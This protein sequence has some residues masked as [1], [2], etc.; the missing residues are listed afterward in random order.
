MN[1]R[2]ERRAVAHRAVAVE[3]AADLH[4]RKHERHGGA[5]H[6]MV[7]REPRRAADT[8]HARPR[9][10]LGPALEE[11]HGPRRRV[12]RSRDRDGVEMSLLD[13]TAECRRSARSASVARA[14]ARYRAATPDCARRGR[15]TRRPRASAGSSSASSNRRSDRPGSRRSRPHLLHVGDGTLEVRGSPREHGGVDR[16]GRRAADDAERIGL[17]A[18]ATGRRSPSALRSDTRRGRL[19]PAARVL[20][21]CAQALAG[22]GGSAR[23]GEDLHRVRAAGDAMLA[24]RERRRDRPALTAPVRC[25]DSK[26]CPC[27][28]AGSSTADLFE[29]RRHRRRDTC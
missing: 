4:G 5:R 8:A 7:D 24:H 12:R 11:R 18:P 9:R 17:H 25:S 29:P 1:R 19:R 14:A 15:R 23:H 10:E 3:L 27:V 21:G 2:R 28:A 22:A 20:C 13:R 16:A 6:Q 26:M